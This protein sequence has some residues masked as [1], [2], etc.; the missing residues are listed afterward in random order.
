MYTTVTQIYQSLET[1]GRPVQTWDDIFIYNVVQRLDVKSVQI[2]QQHLGSS[3][4]FPTWQLLEFSMTRLFTLQ[5]TEK[6]RK[7]E[8]QSNQQPVKS[9]QP[10]VKS[11]QTAVNSH[12]TFTVQ[13][14]FSRCPICAA[15]HYAGNCPQYSDQTVERK[16]EII[17]KYGLCLNCLGTHKWKG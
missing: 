17:K 6:A 9:Q 3:K 16:R 12:H 2:W 13:S 7:S 4:D 5:G 8:N 15:N 11:H 14:T 10:A 1:L